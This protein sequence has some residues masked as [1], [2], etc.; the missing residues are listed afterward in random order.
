MGIIPP[1]GSRTMT[2]SFQF[3]YQIHKNFCRWWHHRSDLPLGSLSLNNSERRLSWWPISKLTRKTDIYWL[4]TA[5]QLLLSPILKA[6]SVITKTCSHLLGCSRS[7]YRTCHFHINRYCKASSINPI[8]A[9]SGKR[10]FVP[11]PHQSIIS[12]SHSS[13]LTKI[14]ILPTKGNHWGSL[15]G[16]ASWAIGAD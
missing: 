14:L 10:D 16:G 13:Q 7:R 12:I 6:L 9:T 5:W 11:L 1:D 8:M 3:I 2:R 15:I 4:I